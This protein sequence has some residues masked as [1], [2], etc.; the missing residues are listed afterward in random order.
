MKPNK[1]SI[2]RLL[3]TSGLVLLAGVLMLTAYR[4]YEL[5]PWTRH[6]LVQANIVALAPQVHG[7]ISEVL[8]HD[9]EEVHKGDILFRIDPR[10]Y[11][12]ALDSAKISLQKARQEVATLEATVDIATARIK[13]AESTFAY[14]KRNRERLEFLFQHNTISERDLD[15]IKRA[16]DESASSLAAA[17]ATLTE[18]KMRLGVSGEENVLIKSARIRIAQAELNLSYTE[19]SSPVDGHVVNVGV[20]PGDYAVSGKAVLAVVD[21]RSLHV[22]AAFKETQL[23]TIRKGSSATVT[24]MT[25]PDTPLTGR[26]QSIGSA[27]SPKEFSSSEGLVPSLPAAFDWVRLAQRVPVKITFSSNIQGLE[28]IP[29]T[30]VSVAIN[31]GS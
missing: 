1:N 10:P 24:L 31:A 23:K 25:M 15:D 14:T 8:V 13:F 9:N 28:V 3:T 19:V 21:A 2:I 4:R 7:N 16:F 17:Q 5:R 12:L 26:I 27:I 22:M 11:I 6:G 20:D 29:G 18:A 30:T